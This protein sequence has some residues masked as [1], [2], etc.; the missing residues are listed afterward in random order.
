MAGRAYLVLCSR[1]LRKSPNP[2]GCE[3]IAFDRGTCLFRLPYRSALGGGVGASGKPYHCA[4][5]FSQLVWLLGVWRCAPVQR[6]QGSQVQYF[7]T[8]SRLVYSLL[9]YYRDILYR[10]IQII[11]HCRAKVTLTWLGLRSRLTEPR[12]SYFTRRLAH[13]R[14]FHLLQSRCFHCL[15]PIDI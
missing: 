3:G 11:F 14:T 10:F 5:A 13:L 4:L 1:Y 8:T 2:R 7:G 6:L 9:H 15:L 12:S